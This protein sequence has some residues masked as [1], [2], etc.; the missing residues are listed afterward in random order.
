MIHFYEF[1]S[2]RSRR[3]VVVTNSNRVHYKHLGEKSVLR[4]CVGQSDIRLTEV[5]SDQPLDD[6]DIDKFI[7]DNEKKIVAGDK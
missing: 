6:I 5:Q 4:M 3:W 7:D 1:I 2:S